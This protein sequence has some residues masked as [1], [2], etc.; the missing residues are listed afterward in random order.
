MRRV[1][2][3]CDPGVDDAAAIMFALASPELDVVALTTGYG[4]GPLEA[5]TANALRILAAAGRE[6]IPVF[7]GA[8]RPLLREPN[9]GWASHVHSGDA[10]GGSGQ[11]M[12]AAGPPSTQPTHAARAIADA[13][14]AAPGELT[15]AALGRLT[16]VALA[17]ALDPAMASQVK[18]IVAMGGA[19]QVPGNVSPNA[20]A[21][22]YEDPE[23]ADIVYRS[24]APIVQVGLDV[25]NRVTV[26]PS[27]LQAIAEAGTPATNLLTSATA[28]LRESYV[29]RGLIGASEGVRYNDMPAVG[30]LE[31]PELFRAVPARIEIETRDEARRG[32]TTAVWDSAHPN[33]LVCLEVDADRLTALFTQR[34]IGG[35]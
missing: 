19:V 28:F 10:L 24:G 31:A 35:S 21:N 1:I 23:A 25:C 22:L 9:P 27:Q 30:Y 15:I 11:D 8:G 5:C 33:A 6:A 7:P 13:V 12:A 34:L 18:R 14:T 20:S 29:R 32:A 4:N 26:S 16:N 3:D 2:I 17:L